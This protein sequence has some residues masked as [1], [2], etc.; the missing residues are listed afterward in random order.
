[1]AVRQAVHAA[2]ID[3]DIVA[4]NLISDGCRG[5]GAPI[6]GDFVTYTNATINI[7]GDHVALGSRR[8]ADDVVRAARNGHAV[9]LVCNG[10][11]TGYVGTDV[12]AGYDVIVCAAVDNVTARSQV[13]RD[14]VAFS[15]RISIGW[16]HADSIVLGAEE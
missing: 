6:S 3:A 13:P 5:T 4:Q 10:H 15:R 7:A 2:G 9:I 14:D 16:I 12:V 8:A 1:G 11:H